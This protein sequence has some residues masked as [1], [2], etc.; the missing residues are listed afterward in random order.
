[1]KREK[2]KNIIYVICIIVFV[3]SII[4]IINYVLTTKKTKTDLIEIR[5]IM[6]KEEES[7]GETNNNIEEKVDSYKIEQLK[8]VQEKNSEIVAWINIEGTEINY[9][10][11]QTNNNEYYLTRNY[12]KEYDSNGSIF[13]DYRYDFSRPSDNFLIYGHN[14]NNGLMFD[15]LLDYEDINYYKAHPE[16][17]LITL[18]EDATYKIISVFKAQAYKNNVEDNFLYYNYVDFETDEEYYNYISNCINSSLYK[19]DEV[20][21]TR[22]KLLTLS[23]CEYSKK[24][25]RFAILAIKMEEF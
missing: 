3:I 20:V 9:P 19:I 11:L 6:E 7:I 17:N 22:Q 21:D 25:G 10:V 13:L 1:M 18:E 14:N 24:N 23:T 16:I 4:Y 2:I 8:K 12:K 5:E 15:K